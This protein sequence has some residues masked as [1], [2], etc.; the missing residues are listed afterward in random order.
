[1]KRNAL[2]VGSFLSIAIVIVTAATVW[3]GGT[4]WFEQRSKAVIYFVN[5]VSGLYVGAPVTFRGVQVGEVQ[6][7]GLQVNPQTGEANMPVQ[8]SLRAQALH[9]SSSNEGLSQALDVPMLVSQG[10]RAR[11]A[12]QSFVTGQKLIDLDLAPEQPST[13]LGPIKKGALP[14]IPTQQG[15]IDAL[16]EQAGSVD[17]RSVVAEVRSTLQGLNKTLGAANQLLSAMQTQIT[18]TAGDARKTLQTATATLHAVEGQTVNT[19]KSIQMLSAKTSTSIQ[20]AQ[21]PLQAALTS[22]QAAADSARLAAQSAQHLVQNAEEL[23]APG[24]NARADLD[25]ALRD[26]ALTTRNLRDWSEVVSD[27]P[28]AIVFGK[29][30]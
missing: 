5:G 22:A 16:L 29:E 8:V 4:G 6:S 26:L 9:I 18:D 17:V 20:Q 3:L 27:Q 25:A 1:M 19:L 21:A 15:M 12:A 2:L 14:E 28:N 10:L 30:R 13:L 11:L 24:A 7:I 23:L